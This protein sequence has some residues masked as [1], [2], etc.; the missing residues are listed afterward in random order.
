MF[1]L[2][3]IKKTNVLSTEIKNTPENLLPKEIQIVLVKEKF[4]TIE[5]LIYTKDWFF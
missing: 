5:I 1:L 2:K 3:K 4:T